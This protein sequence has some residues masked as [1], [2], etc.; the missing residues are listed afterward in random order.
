MSGT[1]LTLPEGSEAKAY[2]DFVVEIWNQGR[3]YQQLPWP[4]S[5]WLG[6][7][8]G[9]LRAYF[10]TASSDDLS[11]TARHYFPGYLSAGNDVP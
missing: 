2:M 1:L 10:P 5:A 8:E 9:G 6:D 11:L 3:T 7:V 4:R